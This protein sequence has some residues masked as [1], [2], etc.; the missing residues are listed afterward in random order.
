MRFGILLVLITAI[1]AGI[2]WAL[3]T[4]GP[5]APQQAVEEVT[6]QPD[7]AQQVEDSDPVIPGQE[8]F[9]D[10]RRV[11]VPVHFAYAFTL[12]QFEKEFLNPSKVSPGFEAK[13]DHVRDR[14]ITLSAKHAEGGKGQLKLTFAPDGAGTRITARVKGTGKFAQAMREMENDPREKA[15][16]L[17]RAWAHFDKAAAEVAERYPDWSLNRA[18]DELLSRLEQARYERQASAHR[19]A[20]EAVAEASN[21]AAY[22]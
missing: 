9:S 1:G 20:E 10:T 5:A 3:P 14:S 18:G 7:G 22:R 13:V 17:D 8:A 21:A 6:V 15:I 2:G 19:E 12:S 11:N 4:M 16:Q